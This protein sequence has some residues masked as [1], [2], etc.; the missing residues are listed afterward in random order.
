V[1]IRAASISGLAL[2]VYV[3]SVG[4]VLISAE[5]I[6]ASHSRFARPLQLFYSPVLA[7]ARSCKVGTQVYEGYVGFWHRKILGRNFPAE[8]RYQ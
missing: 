6:G 2:V 4:P 1:L 8:A 7:S 3:L 5:R